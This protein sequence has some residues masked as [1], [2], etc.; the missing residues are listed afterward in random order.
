M[1]FPRTL[2]LFWENKTG[3][4]FGCP[5]LESFY[6]K[7]KNKFWIAAFEQTS[8]NEGLYECRHFLN[9][10]TDSGISAGNQISL[11]PTNYFLHIK[12]TSDN[13]IC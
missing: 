4:N 9:Y 13:L 11:Q 12:L 3:K 10:Q 5:S 8:V 2:I 7:L 1:V 6:S